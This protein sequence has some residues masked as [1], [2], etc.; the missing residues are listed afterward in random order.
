MGDMRK[1]GAS[2]HEG[3][4]VLAEVER[5]GIRF[6][7]LEVT[8]ISRMA[9]CVTSPAEQLPDTLAYGKWF[10]GAAIESLARIAETDMYL[11]PDPTTFSPAPWSAAPGATD[12][13]SVGRIICDV[14]LP[15]G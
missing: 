13:P 12:I 2:E 15:T 11:R 14:L 6:I 7:N 3:A 8:D 1:G 5:R 4:R 9:K 10:D